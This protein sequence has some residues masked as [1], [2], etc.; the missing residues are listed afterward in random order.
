MRCKVQKQDQ[1]RE[2]VG[3]DQ[4]GMIDSYRVCSVGARMCLR[5][6]VRDYD[7]GLISE[8]MRK[9]G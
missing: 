3:E 8:A 4:G 7:F 5:K 2:F 1:A 6:S 9:C